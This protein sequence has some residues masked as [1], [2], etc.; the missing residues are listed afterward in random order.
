MDINKRNLFFP[1]PHAPCPAL[2]KNGGKPTPRSGVGGIAA[3]ERGV[4]VH[5]TSVEIAMNHEP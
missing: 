3:P 4:I 2:T 5:R 1:L